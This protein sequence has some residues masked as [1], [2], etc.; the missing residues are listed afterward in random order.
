MNGYEINAAVW[1]AM[2]ARKKAWLAALT[3]GSEVCVTA[4]LSATTAVVVRLTLTQLVLSNDC[5][6]N[7]ESGTLRGTPGSICE[8][9]AAEIAREE[10]AKIVAASEALAARVAYSLSERRDGRNNEPL[11]VGDAVVAA[12]GQTGVIDRVYSAGVSVMLDKPD[13]RGRQVSATFEHD[14]VYKL[15]AAVDKDMTRSTSPDRAQWLQ[16]LVVGDVVIEQK[17]GTSIARR[18]EYVHAIDDLGIL[19]SSGARYSIKD[20][21]GAGENNIVKYVSGHVAH[22]FAGA[23]VTSTEY[24]NMISAANHTPMMAQYHAIKAQHP[25]TLVLYRMGDFYEAFYADA[26]KA[27][28][29][30]D[31]TLTKRSQSAGEPVAVAMAGIPLHALDNYLAKLIECGESVAVCENDNVRVINALPSKPITRTRA[32]GAGRKRLNNVRVTASIPGHL[33]RELNKRGG[34]AKFLIDALS[35]K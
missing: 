25:D 4:G 2:A 11:A 32:P 34:L 5:R 30:L 13:S 22:V 18:I 23:S 19:L 10:R 29:L 33:A 35:D 24:A 12:D 1:A 20:G 17:I 3:S 21:R 26:E 16:S 14:A 7:R 6:A 27:A 8:P 9:G 31:I 28:R 15:L